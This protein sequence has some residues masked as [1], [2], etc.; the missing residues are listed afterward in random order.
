M[1]KW[2][3][4]VVAVSPYFGGPIALP[5]AMPLELV[6]EYL[7]RLFVFILLFASVGCVHFFLIRYYGA[8]RRLA[9]ATADVRVGKYLKRPFFY[10]RAEFIEIIGLTAAALSALVWL[11]L[12][13]AANPPEVFYLVLAAI[14]ASSTASRFCTTERFEWA[15]PAFFLSAAI[16]AYLSIQISTGSWLWQ[17]VF[18]GCGLA[19]PVTATRLAGLLVRGAPLPLSRRRHIARLTTGF[20]CCGPVFIILLVG[21]GQL[22]SPYGLT[23]LIVPLLVKH[24]GSLSFYESHGAVP[25]R[26]TETISAAALLFIVILIGVG[27]VFG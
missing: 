4:W 13:R 25:A 23:A 22:P 18:I 5:F 17:P 20:L 21:L 7:H 24:F 26:H 6:P 15:A 11:Q 9:D 1:A 27:V 16:V 2:R 19:G 14:L 8:R 10:R 3:E 12:F